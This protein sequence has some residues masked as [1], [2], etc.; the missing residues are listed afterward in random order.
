MCRDVLMPFVVAMVGGY[1]DD[2]DYDN[3]YVKAALEANSNSITE[4]SRQ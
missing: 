3:R 1:V 4:F 2:C